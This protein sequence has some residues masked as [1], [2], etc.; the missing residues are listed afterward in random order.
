MHAFKQSLLAL[1]V[2]TAA[3]GAIAETLTYQLDP[4]HSQVHA[5]VNHLGFSHSM[6]RFA[7]KEGTILA[8][9]DDLTG[10]KVSVVMAAQ[11]ILGDSTWEEHTAAEGWFD[12]ANHAEIRFESTAVRHV[13]GDQYEVEGDL[14]LK[15]VTKPVTLKATLNQAGPH[16]FSKKPRLGLSATAELSRSAYGVSA[17]PVVGDEVQVRIEV[18]AGAD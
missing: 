10:A 7:V 17:T 12:L 16:P 13:A 1:I 11:P 4:V 2:T 6:A 8:D 9:A 3:H 14:T 18:E 5:S 15:G